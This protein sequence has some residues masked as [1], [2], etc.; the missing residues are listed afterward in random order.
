MNVSI[1][2][3]SRFRFKK[4]S[5]RCR[6]SLKQKLDSGE[7]IFSENLSLNWII[8]HTF[9]KEVNCCKGSRFFDFEPIFQKGQPQCL[10]LHQLF[11]KFKN[12]TRGQNCYKFRKLVLRSRGLSSF[13]IYRDDLI[14][15]SM[16]R[17][18]CILQISQLVQLTKML[19]R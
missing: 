18:K 3:I 6:F 9:S 15:L 10:V 16:V 8:S 2:F 14:L 11:Y 5:F 12:V 19:Q 1:F 4:I 13:D 17:S 7:L